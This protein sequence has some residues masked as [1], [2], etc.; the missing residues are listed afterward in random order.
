MVATAGDLVLAYS[1]HRVT[2][3]TMRLLFALPTRPSSSSA[4]TRCS[5]AVTSTAP[6]TAPSC[7]SP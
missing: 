1:K 2:E 3:E 5:P 4:V 6:R 7:T